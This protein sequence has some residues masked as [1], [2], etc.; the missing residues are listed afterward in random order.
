LSGLCWKSCVVGKLE[1]FPAWSRE[2]RGGI[3]AWY[4]YES[5]NFSSLSPGHCLSQ[6]EQGAIQLSE[7]LQ[8]A[9][10]L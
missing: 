6:P 4:T 9:A 3:V 1:A 8:E 7:Q 2:D 5:L 10:N